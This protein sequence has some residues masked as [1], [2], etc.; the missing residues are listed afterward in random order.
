MIAFVPLSLR[1]SALSRWARAAMLM[2]SRKRR[3]GGR[4]ARILRREE[5]T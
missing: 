3:A 5:G 2:L 4:V 1:F